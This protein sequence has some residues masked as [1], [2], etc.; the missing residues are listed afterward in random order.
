MTTNKREFWVKYIPRSIHKNVGDRYEIYQPA[1][2]QV[3]IKANSLIGAKRIAS[4][5]YPFITGNWQ[6][7][8]GCEW[9]KGDSVGKIT[10][11]IPFSSSLGTEA[12]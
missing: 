8:S 11:Y 3:S 12:E 2:E 4:K 5:K 7:E 9:I 1:T 10:V 6:Q